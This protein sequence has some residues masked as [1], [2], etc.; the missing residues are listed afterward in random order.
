MS[1]PPPT[2]GSMWSP[3][4]NEPAVPDTSSQDP[5]YYQSEPSPGYSSDFS[6][7]TDPFASPE[8]PLPTDGPDEV[9]PESPKMSKRTSRSKRQKPSRAPKEAVAGVPVGDRVVALVPAMTNFDFLE[10]SYQKV[11]QTRLVLEGVIGLVAAIMIGVALLGLSANLAATGAKSQLSSVNGLAQKDNRL[12]AAAAG[13]SGKN[14]SIS[15]SALSTH[16]SQRTSALASVL[17][18]SPNVTTITNHV[19]ALA[20]GG[21]SIISVTLSPALPPAPVVT[22]TLPGQTTTSSTSTTLAPGAVTTTTIPALSSSTLTIVALVHNYNVYTSLVSEVQHMGSFVSNVSA[23]PS[24][25]IPAITVTI[26]ASIS[27]LPLPAPRSFT[28]LG[29]KVQP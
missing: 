2:P 3:L 18:F 10:G 7:L 12:Y 11:R 25:G 13:L 16:V 27:N 24:G 9:Y 26:T 6:E 21:V 4:E 17:A 1:M 20:T 15:G 14:F 23:V 22:T 5:G 19:Y 28:A 29:G 8:I